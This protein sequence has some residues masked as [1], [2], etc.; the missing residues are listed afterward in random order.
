MFIC[1]DI[2]VFYY[3]TPMIGFEY[4]KIPL[5][6]IPQYIVQKYNLTGPVAAD[7][8]VYMD[9]RKGMPGLKQTR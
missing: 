2:H 9:I 6:M 5:S 8:Y 4:M 1:A 3:S 7:G